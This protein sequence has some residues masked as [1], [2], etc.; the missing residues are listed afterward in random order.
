MGT[1]YGVTDDWL[2][3]SK[4]NSL[5]GLI[6]ENL[7]YAFDTGRIL[8]YPKTGAIVTDLNGTNVVATL[9][10]GVS[11]NSDNFGNLTFDGAND[12]MSL[13]AGG[14]TT[15]PI[16]LSTPSTVYAWVFPTTNTGG[17]FSHWS[18]GPVNLGYQIAS[19]K[20]SLYQY[21]SEWREYFSSGPDVPLNKWSMITWVRSSS[22]SMSLYLNDTLNG[23][24]SP[25][26]ANNQ[27]FG[28]GNMGSFGMLW[29]FRNFSG[30]IAIVLVYNDVAHTLSQITQQYNTNRRRFGL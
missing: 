3:L 10:N 23:T 12:Y 24:L 7:T 19:G 21:W 30:K 4:S 15:N 20:I 28:G 9:E 22:T 29:G 1:N 14:N 13:N 17:I 2:N 27:F 6:K 25:D 18:G 11:Y 16:L 8:S 5:N 26:T